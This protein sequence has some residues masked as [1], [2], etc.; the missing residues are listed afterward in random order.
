MPAPQRQTILSYFET[1]FGIPYDA[2]EPFALLDRGKVYALLSRLAPAEA[3]C[4]LK[5]QNA[6]LPILRK[7]PTHL[8]PTTAAI[9]RFGPQATK[10]IV[11][12]TANQVPELLQA[13]VMAYD[14]PLA[15]GYV[16]LRQDGHVLGC[17]LLTPGQLRSLIP[18]WLVKHQR[19]VEGAP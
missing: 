12:M 17:G 5:L 14:S 18:K 3:I 1:R 16:I 10:H 7:M 11:E 9:Q 19:L 6:G 15:P 4:S 13:G 2:F 8:K